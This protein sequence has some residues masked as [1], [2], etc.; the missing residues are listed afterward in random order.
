[1]DKQFDL[2]PQFE[3]LFIDHYCPNFWSMEDIDLPYGHVMVID[4][5]DMQSML[6]RGDLTK[7]SDHGHILNDLSEIESKHNIPVGFSISRSWH[8]DVAAFKDFIK[9]KGF[10]PVARFNWLSKDISN[11]E[12]EPAS[13]GFII[14]ET[15]DVTSFAEIMRIGFS[16]EVG[17]M[18][19]EGALKNIEDAARGYFVAKD[20]ETKEVIGCA[21]AFYHGECAYMSCLAV[22]PEYRLKGIAKDLVKAR[23]KFLQRNCAKYIVT[24]VN[25]TNEGSMQVQQNSGYVPCEVTEYWMKS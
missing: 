14:E 10:K 22:K 24:A 2:W 21:A 20:S 25:E 9:E 19:L 12:V 5:N 23:I 8:G 3:S 7:V 17:D 16:S 18:F 6:W 4:P 11:I 15:K 13:S 1:M